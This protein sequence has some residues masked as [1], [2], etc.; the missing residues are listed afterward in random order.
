[1]VSG[2][3]ISKKGRFV[4]ILSHVSRAIAVSIH[5]KIIKVDKI[6]DTSYPKWLRLLLTIWNSPLSPAQLQSGQ[7]YFVPFLIVLCTF[8]FTHMLAIFISWNWQLKYIGCKDRFVGFS[9]NRRNEPTF[10]S[11]A[12][13]AWKTTPC[14]IIRSFSIRFVC[15]IRKVTL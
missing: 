4:W 14:E 3:T 11:R 15:I 12:S 7:K 10:S 5:S 6:N 13:P 8:R 9:G 2:D 1:M